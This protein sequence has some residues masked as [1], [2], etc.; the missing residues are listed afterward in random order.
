MGGGRKGGWVW[1][2]GLFVRGW[3]LPG[4]SGERPIVT[5]DR[6]GKRSGLEGEEEK[7]QRQGWGLR[8][9]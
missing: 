9:S 5:L 6:A 1:R 4:G 2:D 8:G 3:R 7:A